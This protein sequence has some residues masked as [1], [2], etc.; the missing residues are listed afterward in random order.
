[1]ADIQQQRY[2]VSTRQFKCP[3]CG[4]ELQ[5]FSQ[6]TRYVGCTYCGTE[7]DTTHPEAHKIA[8]LAKPS[9]YQPYSFVRVGMEALIA[10]VRYVVLGRTRWQTDYWEYWIEDDEAGWENE[11]WEYDEWILY[12]EHRNLLYLI[13]DEEGFTISRTFIPRSPTLP[14]SYNQTISLIGGAARII[15]EFGQ[16]K[17]VYHEG[18]STYQFQTGEVSHFATISEG[19]RD[20]SIEWRK[21]ERGGV[22]EI[23]FFEEEKLP[24]KVILAAF[25]L[26][27]NRSS[28]KPLSHEERSKASSKS[29]AKAKFVL[30]LGKMLFFSGL[31]MVVLFFNNELNS[32]TMVS[33]TLRFATLA[34]GV[35]PGVHPQRAPQVAPIVLAQHKPAPAN[36]QM[37]AKPNESQHSDVHNASQQRQSAIPQ[38]SPRSPH[39]LDWFTNDQGERFNYVGSLPFEINE[40]GN[41]YELHISLQ[42]MPDNSEVF[43]GAEVL[44]AE[45]LPIRAL[46]GDFY[47]ASGSDYECDEDGCGYYDWSEEDTYNSL[48]FVPDTIGQFEMR[49]WA[50]GPSN[51]QGTVNAELRK[52]RVSRYWG[53]TSLVCLVVGGLLWSRGTASRRRIEEYGF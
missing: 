11:K 1:M 25:G 23:E 43:I 7:L 5:L 39:L 13:E 6:R 47:R 17:A 12:S 9:S 42:D 24:R 31:V 19:K 33:N 21:D 37:E 22:F 45:G 44:D 34:G 40:L 48:V 10:N 8:Q 26:A 35:T 18:E 36:T 27:G 20:H 51:V 49:L 41:A 30:F 52:V 50:S 4:G 15:R 3:N 46:E 2:F 32:D 14:S 29:L 38:P 16:A 53:I 28:E